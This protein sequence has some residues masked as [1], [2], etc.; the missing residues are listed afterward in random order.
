MNLHKNYSSVVFGN[1]T[2]MLKIEK[3]ETFTCTIS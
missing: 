2:K 1:G 3:E